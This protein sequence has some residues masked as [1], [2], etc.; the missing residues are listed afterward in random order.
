MISFEYL[1]DL[2]DYIDSF[3]LFLFGTDYI[4]YKNLLTEGWV[5]F[6]NGKVQSRQWGDSNQLEFKVHKIKMLDQLV[7]SENRTL[8]IELPFDEVSD[9]MISTIYTL[10]DE[11]KGDHTLK[12][13]LINYTNKYTVDLLSRK[14]RVNLNNNLIEDLNKINDVKVVIES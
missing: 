1:S 12:I 10:I 4:D 8:L 14:N 2:E 13:K 9:E 3:R 7:N 5:L 11:N 6:I